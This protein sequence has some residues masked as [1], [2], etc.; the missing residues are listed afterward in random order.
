MAASLRV[1]LFI[2]EGRYTM[3]TDLIAVYPN[4][5]LRECYSC[6]SNRTYIHHTKKGT[7][8]PGRYGNGIEDQWLCERCEN[9]YVKNPKWHPVT[10]PITRQKIKSKFCGHRAKPSSGV[11]ENYS[12]SS[13]EV[14]Q[15]A[16]YTTERR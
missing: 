8:Y 12:P 11:T 2:Q 7:A 5:F 10:N 4:P 1:L 16:Q 9:K 13:M 3:K 14:S 6:G 15:F